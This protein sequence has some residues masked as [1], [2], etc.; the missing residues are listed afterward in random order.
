V[1]IALNPVM[2]EAGTM[3]LAAVVDIS[4]RKQK[5]QHIQRSLKEKTNLLSEVHHRVKNNLQL[6]H[7]LLD[8]QV[9]QTED[10]SVR[11]ILES[12]KRRIESMA[13]IHQVLYQSN[14]FAEVEMSEVLQSL[15]ENIANSFK[16]DT[17]QACLSLNVESVLLPITQAIPCGFI[18]NEL[19]TNA[20]KYAFPDNRSGEVT[21]NLVLE[22]DNLVSLSVSDNGV[23]LPPDIDLGNL[24]SLG[25]ELVSVLAEQLGGSLQVNRIQPTRFEIR[26]SIE[27]Q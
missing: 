16:T 19:V 10:T 18:V 5:E 2:T 1:E 9:L 13:R 15:T 7:S 4:D 8:L 22:E 26:F 3:V 14:D 20:L 23:G 25:L 27:G 24:S 11:D 21:V 17:S 6:I 12:S